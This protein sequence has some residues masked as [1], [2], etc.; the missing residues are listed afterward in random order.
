MTTTAKDT[1][2][3]PDPGLGLGTLPERF[4]LIYPIGVF[5]EMPIQVTLF[6]EEKESLFETRHFR[7][8]SE[9]PFNR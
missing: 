9:Y 1:L 4:L 7:W 3:R 5:D 8:I 6:R 2:P